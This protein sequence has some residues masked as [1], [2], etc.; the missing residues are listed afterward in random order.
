MPRILRVFGL[1]A[2]AV[3]ATVAAPAD[4]QQTVTMSDST[5]TWL[6]IY[7]AV[8]D[9]MEPR[10][11]RRLPVV[12]AVFPCSPAHFAGLEPGDLLVAVDGRDARRPAPFEGPLG[13]EYA[14][15][16]DRAGERLTFTLVRARRPKEIGE[17]VETAPVGSLADWKCPTERLK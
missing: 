6:G 12:R 1:L 3:L 11:T 9:P 4:A 2:V 5:G 7:R 15:V 10:E 8:R 13:A 16:V 14:V 17:P